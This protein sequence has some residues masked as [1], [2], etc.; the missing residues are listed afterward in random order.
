[1]S[2]WNPTTATF[3]SRE[4]REVQGEG[5]LSSTAGFEKEEMGISQGMEMASQSWK[6]PQLMAGRKTG[7]QSHNL[8]ELNS[9]VNQNKQVSRY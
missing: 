1:M 5:D 9:V 4:V 7:P 3:R 8:K 6:W 2:G